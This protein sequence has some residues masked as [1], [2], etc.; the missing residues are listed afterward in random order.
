MAIATEYIPALTTAN[1]IPRPR[2][3]SA[4][5][6][7]P[8]LLDPYLAIRYHRDLQCLPTVACSRLVLLPT[9][10]A[11]VTLNDVVRRHGHNLETREQSIP[12][13][14]DYQQTARV[15]DHCLT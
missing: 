13:R 7:D 11:M 10:N 9:E 8:H 15:E 4:V 3:H 2:H 14:I 5:S 12:H 6:A 1:V